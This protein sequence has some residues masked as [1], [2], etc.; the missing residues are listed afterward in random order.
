[1]NVLTT[2]KTAA[3]PA[4]GYSVYLMDDIQALEVYILGLATGVVITLLIQ[5]MYVKPKRK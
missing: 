1:M 2:T 3:I 4:A 5:L